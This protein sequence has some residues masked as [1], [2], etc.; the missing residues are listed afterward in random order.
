MVAIYY[1]FLANSV[2]PTQIVTPPTFEEKR[3]VTQLIFFKFN[4]L[5]LFVTQV[6]RVTPDVREFSPRSP[7]VSI[8]SAE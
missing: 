2:T 6:T 3:S 5:Q 7:L 1:V 8:P 4:A